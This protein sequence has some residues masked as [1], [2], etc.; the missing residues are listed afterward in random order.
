MK[1]NFGPMPVEIKIIA[2]IQELLGKHI[3]DELYVP[4][5]VQPNTNS[6]NRIV[7]D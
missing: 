7:S 4:V 3:N 5:I 6:L 1:K 2:D